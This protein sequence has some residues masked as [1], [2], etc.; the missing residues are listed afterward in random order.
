MAKQKPEPS[1]SLSALFPELTPE[2]GTPNDLTPSQMWPYSNKKVQWLCS[3][4][5]SWTASVLS[6]TLQKTGCPY[7]SGRLPTPGETD[8]ATKNPELVGEWSSQ[9]SEPPWNYTQRSGRKVWW[10]CGHCHRDWQS[11]ITNRV[12]GNGCPYC[13]G[14][15]VVVGETDLETTHPLLAKEWSPANEK[16]PKE[17]SR[18]SGYRAGWVCEKGHTWSTKVSHRALAGSGCP[19][20]TAHSGTSQIEESLRQTLSNWGFVVASDA[21]VPR[22]GG[23]RPWKVD[24]FIK[25]RSLVVEFD[26]AYWHSSDESWHRDATKTK[27]MLRDG[28]RVIRIRETCGEYVARALA[29]RHPSYNE[30]RWYH[31]R[32]AHTYPTELPSDILTELYSLVCSAEKVERNG[33]ALC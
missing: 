1:E 9:N 5:H 11:T 27:E 29:V 28:I 26:G 18:G 10:T 15:R 23:G 7:C 8:F 30:I 2:W 22:N 16:T 12:S 31:T 21:R 3:L 17:V 4:G 24:A 32:V 25:G 6:R 13:A 14:K 20:C 19:V 33:G